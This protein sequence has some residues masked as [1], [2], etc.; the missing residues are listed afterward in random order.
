MHQKD[1]SIIGAGIGGLTM[2]LILKQSGLKFN[3]YER[4]S[5]IKPIGAGIVIANN[6]MQIFKKMEISD[7][8]E[9]AGNKISVMKITDEQLNVIS[10]IQLSRFEEK[11]GVHN[12][13][14]HRADL[15]RIL[16]EEIGYKHIHL[17]RSLADITQGE[18]Y[19][20]SF[21]DGTTTITDIV[22]GA[23]GINSKVRKE[24]FSEGVIRKTGQFCWRGVCEN[25]LPETYS[26]EA[27]ECWGK[28]KRFGFVKI[29]A[30][31]VYWYAVI[32][33]SL[34]QDK[35]EIHPDIFKNFHPMIREMIR[36]TSK[37]SIHESYIT[38]LKPMHHW[39]DKNACLMG[40]AAHATTPNMGQGAC[41]AIEDAYV[42]GEL[43][44][45]GRNA[46]DAFK[47]YQELRISKAHS[48][49]NNSRT[50]GKISQIENALGR[51]IRNWIFKNAPESANYKQLDRIFDMSYKF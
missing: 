18:K 46:T 42:I 45:A 24:L 23:D 40:D 44:S 3:L 49:V 8:I 12:V 5:E 22:I 47:M 37:L 13:A 31:Q 38:D 26:N 15:Q 6:A 20:L 14:I 9:N 39:V 48:I 36:T 25:T 41:Q 17:S 27:Y 43:L 21:E 29:N 11:Y 35:K 50:L 10:A 7:K 16:A 30:Q 34:L 33:E 1:I 28:G 19:Q 32:N 51:K 2:G 4:A